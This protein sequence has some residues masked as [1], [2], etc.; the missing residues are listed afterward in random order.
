[1]LARVLYALSQAPV[2]LFNMAQVYRAKQDTSRALFFYRRHKHLLQ[3][4]SEAFGLHHH[5][6]LEASY[7]AAALT[8]ALLLPL[9]RAFHRYKQA[10]PASWARFI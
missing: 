9:C 10:H 3:L 7:V 4:L 5:A 2:L 8:I 1:M 6:G